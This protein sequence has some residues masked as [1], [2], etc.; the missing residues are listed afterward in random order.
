MSGLIFKGDVISSAGE[1]L[2]APYINKITVEADANDS[3]RNIY[4][5]EMYIF[6]DDYEYIDAEENGS[7][8]N[9]KEAYKQSLNKLNYYVMALSGL[10]KEVYEN[11]ITNKLNP[12]K[13]Y[14]DFESGAY[15]ESYAA[16]VQIEALAEEPSEIYDETGNRILVYPTEIQSESLDNVFAYYQQVPPSNIE[17][18]MCFCSIFDYS[19]DSESLKNENYS[20]AVLD[21]Q[22]GDMSYEK[23]YVSSDSDELAVQDTLKFYDSQDIIYDKIPL[24]SIERSVYKINLINHD[25]VKD[26]INSLLSEYSDLYN[27]DSGYEN[28][29]S[30]MN[31]IYSTLE[32]YG[33]EYDI[34]P[35]LDEIRKNF[36]DKTPLKPVGKLYKRYAKRLFEINSSVIQ[37]EILN[38]KITYNSKIVDFRI[39]TTGDTQTSES[40]NETYIYTDPNLFSNLSIEEDTMCIV[41]GYFMFDYEKALRKNSVISQYIDVNKLET[42]GLNIPYELYYIQKVSLSYNEASITARFDEDSGYPYTDSISFVNN[43]NE[44]L[45]SGY[46]VGENNGINTSIFYGYQSPAS[47]QEAASLGY[48]TSIVNRSYSYYPSDE[49]SINNY[50]LMLFEVLEY[51]NESNNNAYSTAIDIEDNTASYYQELYDTFK[52][53]YDDFSDYYDKAIEACAYN[54][55]LNKFNEYFIQSLLANYSQDSDAVWYSAPSIYC[56]YADIMYNTFEGDLEL[57][58]KESKTIASAVNP[59][60]GD[61]DSIETFKE[62]MDILKEAMEDIDGDISGAGNTQKTFESSITIF[63]PQIS[64]DEK[65]VQV[66]GGGSRNVSGPAELTVPFGGRDNTENNL[67]DED[68]AETNADLDLEGYPP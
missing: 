5:M 55:D 32:L 62:K 60:T 51:R 18:I 3:S 12:L 25:E 47:S 37:S 39:T 34:V 23:I 46:L 64:D 14:S 57:I 26:S 29:K 30:E 10:E 4:E 45:E 40:E 15:Q 2:P 24:S 16:M 1:Y 43:N 65:E 48:A 6:V 54:H 66:S 56:L 35:R 33:D 41:A 13:F 50:R 20:M 28:L 49:F 9:S 36:S 8:E 63:D 42:L 67:D 21:I 7:I 68:S 61:I 53:Y 19:Q 58:E 27:T 52:E 11:L 31:S 22:T 44:F 38:K 17:Y 59:Y